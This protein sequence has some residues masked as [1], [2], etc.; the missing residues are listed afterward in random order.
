MKRTMAKMLR[1]QTSI[2][3]AKVLIGQA[4]AGPRR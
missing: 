3:A 4:P 1:A 2:R